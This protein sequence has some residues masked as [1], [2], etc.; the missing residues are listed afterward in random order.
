M[1]SEK[2]GV[3][4]TIKL[5][6]L[7]LKILYKVKLKVSF[8]GFNFSSYKNLLKLAYF[9]KNFHFY[10]SLLERY[11]IFKLR[12]KVK[13]LFQLLVISDHLRTTPYLLNNVYT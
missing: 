10:I 4:I 8:Y 2:S 12:V 9:L 11:L 7:L 1:Q 3:K 5:I 13:K 6:T